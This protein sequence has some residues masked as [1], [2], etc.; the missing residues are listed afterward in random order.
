VDLPEHLFRHESGRMV[1]ALAR[2]FGVHNLA[3]AEDVV[4]D[5]VC[6]ALEAWR[7]KGVPENPAGWLMATA[8]NRALDLLRRERTARSYAPEWGRLLESEWSASTILDDALEPEAI[9]DGLLRMM[10]SC[11]HP[12][13]SEEAQVALILQ[14]LCG[15]STDEIAAAFLARP[16]A[17]E[18]RVT[19]AKKTLSS[20]KRLFDLSDEDFAQRLVAVQRALY[21]LFN[22]G[23]HG[24]SPVAP[25]RANLCHEAIRLVN[26]L[27]E[28]SR[29]ATPGTHALCALMCLHAARIPARVDPEGDLSSLFDQDRSKWDRTLIDEGER[30]LDL[31]ARGS[32][33][34]AFHLEAAIASL[35]ARAASAKDTDW[36]AIVSL[37]DRLLSLRGS[38]VVALNRAIAVAQSE[39]PAR[40]LEALLAIQGLERLAAYP[41]YPAAQGELELQVG[42]RAQAMKSFQK[43]IAL[44]RSPMERRFFERRLA[45]CE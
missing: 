33:L 21:L 40:G 4:Q 1:S 41:F 31:S 44:A 13:L 23:Y 28:N 6:R 36:A 17:I 19:R 9:K 11:C 12:R 5:A 14:I 18:K 3:L 8:R 30:Q 29:T 27:L 2:V 38:P 43:A 22:E 37:Y 32:D 34:T 7:L 16:A 10:F 39:G 24:A 15:F 35:H 26:A 42:R 45:S 20:S 25:V